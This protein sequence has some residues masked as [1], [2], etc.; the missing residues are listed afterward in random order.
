MMTN[1]M[2]EQNKNR[3]S[4]GQGETTAVGEGRWKDDEKQ[5]KKDNVLEPTR[6]NPL[7]VKNQV[8]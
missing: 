8:W 6:Y 4:L 3:V 5:K 7:K 1:Y 2:S